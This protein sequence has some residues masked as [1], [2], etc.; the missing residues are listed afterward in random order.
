MLRLT[1]LRL[2]LDHP[3]EALKE[4]IRARLDIAPDA[5]EHFTVFR[6]GHDAR[7]RSAIILVYTVDCAVKEEAAVLA[8]YRAA[9]P[10]DPHVTIAPDMRWTPPVADG[11]ALA[12][13]RGICA[14]L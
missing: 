14:L 6:R 4:A 8:R 11:A 5:L 10:K 9:H 12:G 7:R 1:E 13:K 3:P 2:P